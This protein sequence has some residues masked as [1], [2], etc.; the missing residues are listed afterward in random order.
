MKERYFFI[1]LVLILFLCF[2]CS[3]DPV[4]PPD[5]KITK[6]YLRYQE[7]LSLEPGPSNGWI[8]I[9]NYIYPQTSTTCSWKTQLNWNIISAKYGCDLLFHSASDAKVKIEFILEHDNTET[10]LAQSEFDIAYINETTANGI[11]FEADSDN[12]ISGTNPLS[13]RGDYLI[14]R[15][16]HI[17]GTDRIQ[18]LY[19]G[20]IGFMGNTSISLFTDMETD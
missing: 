15:I 6:L 4:S 19:D 12:A 20:G 17:A 7:G 16:T 13:G 11:L 5:A 18:V 8:Y 1:L 14:F 9:S 3:R 10:I 2:S